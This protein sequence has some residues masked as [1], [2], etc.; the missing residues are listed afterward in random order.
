MPDE[1]S[2]KQLPDPSP[3]E[4]GGRVELRLDTTS[5][6][7]EAIRYDA[8]WFTASDEFQGYVLIT[9]GN[10]PP[11]SVHT[12]DDIPPWLNAFTLSLVSTMSRQAQKEGTWPRRLTRWRDTPKV[13]SNKTS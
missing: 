4:Q 10:K 7:G 9:L 3:V 1:I 6:P 5:T 11:I 8:R 12:S 13:S 2:S